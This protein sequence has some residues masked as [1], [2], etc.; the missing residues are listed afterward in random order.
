[1]ITFKIK[2]NNLLHPSFIINHSIRKLINSYN[3]KD[4]NILDFGAGD[5]PY[6]NVLEP[7]NNYYSY[8]KLK[9]EQI[10]T[11]IKYDVIFISFVLYQI[12]NTNE[13]IISLKKYAKPGCRFFIIETFAWFDNFDTS[14][15]IIN[16]N[17]FLNIA[18]KNNLEIIDKIYCI[19]NFS[20]LIL[21]FLHIVNSKISRLSRLLRI[22]IL[23][24]LNLIVNLI[25][26]LSYNFKKNF[27]SFHIFKFFVMK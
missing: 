9:D 26:L 27:S 14:K 8:D 20:A 25:L 5:E 11:N 4:L 10:N 19:N 13:I 17:K 23:P 16:Y 2:P 24:T 12:E 21:I 6:R 1:M 3:F 22:L 15:K 18:Q 7:N